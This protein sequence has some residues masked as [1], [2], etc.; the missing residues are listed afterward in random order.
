MQPDQNAEADEAKGSDLIAKAKAAMSQRRFEE[1]IGFASGLL[2]FPDGVKDALYITA[3]CQRYL[4]RFAESQATLHKLE[5]AFPDYARGW[6]EQGHVMLALNRYDE[7]QKAYRKAVLLNPALLASWQRLESL[8]RDA[9]DTALGDEA[10]AHI[11]ALE[12]LDPMLV[13]VS[14]MIHEG[15]LYSAEQLCRQ[16]LQSHPTDVEGMRLLAQIGLKLNILD[17]AEFLLESALQFAPDHKLVRFDLITVLHKRQKFQA[18]YEHAMAL[19]EAEP[20]RPEFLQAYGNA[21][22]ALG[23]FDEALAVYEDLIRRRPQHAELSMVYGHALK[24]VGR[25]DEA[26]AA[27]RDAYAKRSDLGDAYW[28]LANLKTYRF[29]S[30]EMADMALLVEKDGVADSDRLHLC[31]ALAKALED[32][33]DF[34]RAFAFYAQGNA[35][36]QA[37][38]DYSAALVTEEVTRQIAVF[39]SAYFAAR[40]DFGSPRHDPIFIVGLPRAGSTLLEQILASHSMV[41]GTL[42]L[43][44]ILACAHRLAGKRRRGERGKYPE[45][46]TELTIEQTVRL[47]E[48]YLDETAAFRKGA[49]YFIDKM[50]NNFRHIGLIKTILPNARIIDAR[51]HPLDCCVSGFKQ[52]FA[53][54]QE[55][56]Y[57]LETVGQYYNDYLRM[58]RHW[59]HVLPGSILRMI[60]EDL[61]ENFEQEVRRMLEFCGL[62]FEQQ[63][64][65]F[66]RNEREVR[67]ASSEQVR[68]PINRKG[69]GSWHRFEDHLAPLIEV[70]GASIAT[71]RE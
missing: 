38:S 43:P 48:N 70:L 5:R 45:I 42:E 8:A 22:L 19:R 54:G 44:N 27:Y 17:D 65:E 29:S 31:F 56:T 10:R 34:D 33:G 49:A 36:K 40:T 23:I 35:L 12:M 37:Q 26:I 55:F 71:Y 41:D 11:A 39:D 24:T 47:G 57:S 66:H 60:H 53:E 7:A 69:I 61:I 51:R 67:T 16:Y 20:E 62:P 13:S 9:G 32:A 30:E 15:K 59:D 2:E 1:A 46:V 14:S 6:Q 3:V 18:A 25:Q 21:S 4:S 58:M 50:P 52:L 63:C 68:Q 64:L 28:S